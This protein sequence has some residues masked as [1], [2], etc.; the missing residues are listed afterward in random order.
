MKKLTSFAEDLLASAD[1]RRFTPELRIVA[2]S[3]AVRIISQQDAFRAQFVS[4]DCSGSK[5]MNQGFD[6]LPPD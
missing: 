3:I 5:Y 4:T 6:W 2:L 1:E